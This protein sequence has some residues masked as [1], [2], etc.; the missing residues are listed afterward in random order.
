MTA[1]S[2]FLQELD[3]AVLCGSPERRLR[4]LWY[5]TDL[6]IAG[7]YS[8]DQ[9]WVF[10]EVI[11]RLEEEIEIAARCQ[12]S[13]RLARSD[14]AP[15]RVV[16]KLAFNDSIEVAGPILRYS[17][18][19]DVRTLV[20]N[21]RSKSQHHLLAISRRK[22]ISE[23][24]TDVLV[25]RG[26]QE[27]VKSVASNSGARFSEF[28]FLHLI[29]RSKNDSILAEQLGLRTDIPRHLFQQLIAKA[30]N[31]VSKKLEQ[32]RPEVGSQIHNLVTDLAGSLHAKFGPASSSYFAAKKSVGSKHRCGQLGEDQILEYAQARKL[33]EV[34]VAIS[35]LC[36]LPTDVT[37][38]AVLD[39]NKE[40]ML[41]LAKSLGLSWKTT[42]TLLFLGAPDYQISS[43]NLENMQ[44]EFLRLNA[45][46]S[47]KVLEIYRSRK[48]AAASFSDFRRLA[49]LHSA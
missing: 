30:S 26:N 42:M 17:E 41:I 20:A 31:N 22:S 10:G 2:T 12:L 9:I 16:Q 7:Q 38:R 40:V 28:G 1:A 25:V 21:A 45:E 27:V 49:Q 35:L 43:E 36:T 47:K 6:L 46:T 23:P 39:E 3:E 14:N 19:L 11:G 44:K 24:V 37:E 13:K 34:V 32:E 15:I 18:R 29:K 8:E 5:A 4:A 48:Q 33:D